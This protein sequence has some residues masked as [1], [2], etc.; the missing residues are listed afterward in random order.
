MYALHQARLWVFLFL[1]AAAHLPLMGQDQFGRTEQH[2][3]QVVLNGGSTTSFSLYNPSTTDTISVRIQVFDANGGTLVDQQVQLGPGETENV[4]LGDPGQSLTRGWAKLTSEGEFLATAFFQLSIGGQLKPRIGVLP[5]LTAEEIRLFGFV[6]DEF[7]SGIAFHNPGGFAAEVTLRL[8]GEEGQGALA[9][10]DETT[11][12]VDPQESVAAFLNEDK[13]FGSDL[14]TYEG[15][16]EVASTFP[17]AMLSLTQEAS[18]DLATVSVETPLGEPG[19]AGPPGPTGPK[20][21]PGDG[22][23]TSGPTGPTGAAGPAGPTGSQGPQGPTGPQGDPG[24]TGPQGL[25][26]SMGATGPQGDMSDHYWSET[27]AGSPNVIAGHSTNSVTSGKE[28]ATIGGGGSQS[29]PNRVL[30]RY[31]TVGGGQANIADSDTST[32][33]GGESNDASRTHSTVGGGKSNTA[34]GDYATV[35]GGLDNEASGAYSFA[36]GKG[37]RATHTGAFIWSDSTTGPISSTAD[38]VFRVK[39]AGGYR[40]YTDSV[41]TTGAYLPSGSGSWSSISDRALKENFSP[42]DGRQLLKQLS[43]IPITSWNYKA[44]SSDIRHI[45]PVAQD[46]YTAFQVGEDERYIS[47][48]DAD[49]VT[50][51]AIQGLHEL[52]QEKEEQIERLT[53]RLAALEKQVGR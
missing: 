40:F 24:S 50:L 22:E 5:S 30:D 47:T 11:L 51:A 38:N 20:G 46:F 9:L 33:G 16:V 8:T 18:G 3:S 52:L 1:L 15:T 6:N 2:F 37:S 32:V 14:T 19:P 45:G 12:M 31:G 29:F 26:G 7:K 13:L 49:G 42:V 23:G 44:Q 21:D 10:L 36:A 25:A 34:S 35:P 43:R 4:T 17:I 41:A 28:G 39:A 53:D 48:V 27:T